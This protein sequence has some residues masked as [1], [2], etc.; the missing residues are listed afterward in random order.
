[1]VPFYLEAAARELGLESALIHAANRV[2]RSMPRLVVDKLEAALELRAGKPLAEAS[3][4][5]V[6]VTYKPDIA[7]IRESAALRVLEELVARG[8]RV[9]YH[10]PLIPALAL[11]GERLRSLPLTREE[12]AAADAVLLLTPHSGVDYELVVRAAALVVDTHNGLTPR[13]A[14]NVVNVWVPGVLPTGPTVLA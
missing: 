1:V 7:D 11:A 10:D 5:V 8:A 3:V 12:V 2:N 6:G 14:S 4:L 13:A 9:G